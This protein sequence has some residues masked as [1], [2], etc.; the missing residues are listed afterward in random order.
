MHQ[1]SSRKRKYG[2]ENDERM[3]VF[4]ND[5]TSGIYSFNAMTGE[6]EHNGDIVGGHGAE[7]AGVKGMAHQNVYLQISHFFQT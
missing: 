2:C 1:M 4:A 7:V 5:P 3:F 6:W